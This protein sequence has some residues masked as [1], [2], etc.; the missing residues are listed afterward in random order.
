MIKTYR[1]T[2]DTTKQWK[3]GNYYLGIQLI[4]YLLI[5]S[6]FITHHTTNGT[7]RLEVKFIDYLLTSL[8]F[9][10]HQNGV[11]GG[12]TLELNHTRRP[13]LLSTSGN[14]WCHCVFSI[15]IFK[16]WAFWHTPS[17]RSTVFILT[18]SGRH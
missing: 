7:C 14:F 4:K 8:E 10:T 1:E 13:T 11:L 12:F 9:I 2:L 18:K 3:R 17:K 6:E 5:A 16:K 15:K